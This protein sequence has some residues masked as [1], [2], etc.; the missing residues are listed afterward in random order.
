MNDH[1]RIALKR[2]FDSAVYGGAA[3][4]ACLN[5][6]AELV[7]EADPVPMGGDRFVRFGLDE[8]TGV[9]HVAIDKVVPS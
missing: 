3:P 5:Y 8:G 2:A 7:A 9:L 1:D 6:V 4:G